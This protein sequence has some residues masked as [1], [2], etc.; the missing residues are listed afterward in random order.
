MDRVQKPTDGI[1]GETKLITLIQAKGFGISCRRLQD[2][3]K[4]GDDAHRET[5]TFNNFHESHVVSYE[6]G[7]F[8]K[9]NQT[10]VTTST[11]LTFAEATYLE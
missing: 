6:Y 5:L 3:T 7:L 10:G 8:G 1:H 4:R 9:P 2:V 11:I